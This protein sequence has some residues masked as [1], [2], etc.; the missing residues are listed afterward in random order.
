M[1]RLWHYPNASYAAVG[2]ADEWAV[3]SSV[4]VSTQILILKSGDAVPLHPL[5]ISFGDI[6]TAKANRLAGSLAEALKNTTPD[7]VVERRRER[8]DTQDFG[9]TLA[10]IVG[11]AAFNSIAKGISS[12]LTRNSG[13]KLEVRRDGKLLLTATHVD[14]TD[15]SHIVSALSQGECG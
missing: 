11:T 8:S 3:L 13:A 9:S 6:S 10:V 14:S 15:V 5:I 7:V 2:A 4:G 1:T 12:W